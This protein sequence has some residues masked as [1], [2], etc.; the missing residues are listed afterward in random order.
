MADRENYVD[1]ISKVLFTVPLE[2]LTAIRERYQKRCQSPLANNFQIVSR[3]EAIQVYEKRKRHST[4]PFIH[5]H[6]TRL[7]SSL[8]KHDF[9]VDVQE[10]MRAAAQEQPTAA[11]KA[12]KIE[13]R[14]KCNAPMK[15]TMEFTDIVLLIIFIQHQCRFFSID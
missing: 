15:A 7:N 3:S 10:D 2:E 4:T 1:D 12:R 6:R 5:Q 13:P 11:P 14:K 9:V 8:F